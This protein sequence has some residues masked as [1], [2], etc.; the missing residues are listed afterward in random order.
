MLAP[1]RARA[2]RSSTGLGE[3]LE[4][5]LGER[6]R[7]VPRRR[8]RPD[9]NSSPPSGRAC[10]S[11]ALSRAKRSAT[12]CS[13]WSPASWP[14]LSLTCLKPSRSTSSTASESRERSERASAWSSRSRK[15]A[16]LRAG[17]AVVEGLTRELLLQP[18]RSVMSRALSTTPRTC[19]RRAGRSR[20]P[21]GGAT[22]R[23]GCAS[24]KTISVRPAMPCCGHEH[25]VRSSGCTDALEA[26]AVDLAAR[27]ARACR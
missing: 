22:R 1:T 23:T 4:Q 13:N 19:G 2:R 20:A 21:R 17:E 7:D 25:S 3:A 18:H 14:R 6:D 26:V 16:R 24:R 11:A 12:C 5:P 8:P 15:S 9:A 27:R 10:R